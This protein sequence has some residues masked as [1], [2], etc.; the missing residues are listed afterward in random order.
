M[1]FQS[2]LAWGLFVAFSTQ[3]PPVGGETTFSDTEFAEPNWTHLEVYDDDDNL[4]FS[5]THEEVGGNPGPCVHV[6]FGTSEGDGIADPWDVGVGHLRLGAVVDPGA[7]PIESVD[8]SLELE[9]ED[10]GVSGGV[11]VNALLEQGGTYY[12]GPPFFAPQQAGWLATDKVHL[13]AADFRDVDTLQNPPDF[14]ASGAPIQLGFV[15]Q[16]GTSTTTEIFQDARVDNWSMTVHELAATSVDVS[17]TKASEASLVFAPNP[18]A[19]STTLLF[20]APSGVVRG[21]DV[22]DVTGRRVWSLAGAAG[23]DELVWSGSDDAG[24]ALPPGRYFAR[25]RGRDG[26]AGTVP[27]TIVR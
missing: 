15:T 19:E 10:G 22:F 1:R 6:V 17:V 12:I 4:F 14:S 16:N 7:E 24:R 13:A 20:D 9:V 3:A 23:R 2:R 18:F 27:V 21:V 5:V 8:F 11:W 25:I 26:V